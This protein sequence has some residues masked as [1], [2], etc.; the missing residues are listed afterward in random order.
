MTKQSK[1]CAYCSLACDC[2]GG[3]HYVCTVSN[4]EVAPYYVCEK[5]KTKDIDSSENIPQ[6][7]KSD[8]IIRALAAAAYY[9]LLLDD[10]NPDVG[11]GLSTALAVANASVLS[12]IKLSEEDKATIVTKTELMYKIRRG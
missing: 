9:Q 10:V 4:K 5:F 3:E 7:R 12:N 1:I 6:H 11:W 8:E 2:M